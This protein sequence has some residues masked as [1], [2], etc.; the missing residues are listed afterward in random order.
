MKNISPQSK[1]F[2]VLF[3]LVLVGV[4][5][6]LTLW[7]DL[8]SQDYRQLY[9]YGNY[10]TFPASDT[11]TSG[12]AMHP[13]AP[14]DTSGWKTYSDK[15]DGLAFKYPPAWNVLPPKKSGGFT[16]LQV[17]PG[18]KYYN[19]KIYIS[20]KDF[21][22]MGALPYKADTV[23]G[24]T[25]TDVSDLLYGVKTNGLYYTFD[26]GLSLSLKDQFNALVHS[27]SFNG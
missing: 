5:V 22:A 18:K 11:P 17:D 1:S 9:S 19:V 4:Y 16:V 12:A 20:P 7:D 26:I 24:Q 21:Y 3:C 25:A 27:V 2:I 15:K 10:Q 6:C 8:L 14:L 23:G 13:P